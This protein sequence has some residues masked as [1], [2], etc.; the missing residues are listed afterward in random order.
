[1]HRKTIFLLVED[2]RNDQQLV[3]L[4]FQR[5]SLNIQ[6]ITVQDGSEA[7]EYI[8]GRGEYADRAR[9]PIPHVILLDLKMPRVTGF[10]F[11]E[12]LRSKSPHRARFIP[13]IV[14]SSSNLEPDIDRAYSLGANSY[15]VKPIH[16]QSFRERIQALGVYWSEHVETPAAHSTPG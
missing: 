15:L 5:V 2:D 3:E 10:E 13:V 16:W 9:F 1:M 4:E 11:L 12:W 6:L 8:E 7:I 14:L